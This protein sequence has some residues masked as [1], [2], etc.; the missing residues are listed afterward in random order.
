M[1]TLVEQIMEELKK[2]KSPADI[3]K[4]L[5]GKDY[6]RHV[7]DNAIIE[8]EHKLSDGKKGFDVTQIEKERLPDEFMDAASLDETL[9]GEEDTPHKKKGVPFGAFIVIITFIWFSIL[10]SF[11]LASPFGKAVRTVTP[12]EDTTFL[13]YCRENLASTVSPEEL[14]TYC[15][16][17]KTAITEENR[18]EKFLSKQ[19]VKLTYQMPKIE[20]CVRVLQA[21]L[22]DYDA[23]LPRQLPSSS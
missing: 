13:D 10:I 7:I 22:D 2:K 9:H 15:S 1:A 21:F 4:E 5:L 12:I 18:D 11:Y 3:R 8:A 17:A 20:K 19:C 16:M 6:A 23:Q 14:D